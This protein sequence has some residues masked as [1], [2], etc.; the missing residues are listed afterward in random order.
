M[1]MKNKPYG[2]LLCGNKTLCVCNLSQL[3]Q[4]LFNEECTY[5]EPQNQ[6][7]L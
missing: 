5:T 1:C 7:P 6:C 2:I 4:F 3:Q